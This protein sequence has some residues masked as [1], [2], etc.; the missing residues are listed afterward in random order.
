MQNLVENRK[1]GSGFTLSSL[2]LTLPFLLLITV[3]Q[4][5]KDEVAEVEKKITT[6]PVV[7]TSIPVN[8]YTIRAYTRDGE[9]TDSATMNYINKKY[10]YLLAGKNNY[11]SNGAVVISYLSTDKVEFR[12]L[13]PSM[14]D[15]FTVVKKG[16][17]IY[18]EKKDTIILPYSFEYELYF[19]KNMFRYK[20]LYYEEIPV[21][22]S[23][24]YTKAAKYKPCLIVKTAKDTLILPMLDLIYKLNDLYNYLPEIN[25]ELCTDSLHNLYGN[26]YDTLIIKEYSI[27]LKKQIPVTKK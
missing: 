2:I 24:G 14:L 21:P 3:L 7:Y 27:R 6:Y 11:D 8:D 20:P 1:P 17:L 16:N 22:L 18:L 5:C 19:F 12:K 13:N 25:N 4:S 15:T 23:S 10:G 26:G 9:I